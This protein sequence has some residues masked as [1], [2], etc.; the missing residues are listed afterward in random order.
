MSC[1]DQ[2]LHSMSQHLF[3]FLPFFSYFFSYID[4]KINCNFQIYSRCSERR[5]ANTSKKFYMKNISTGSFFHWIIQL[6]PQDLNF[7][8]L[9]RVIEN[10]KQ[11]RWRLMKTARSKI[12]TD[13]VELYNNRISANCRYYTISSKAEHRVFYSLN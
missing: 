6:I 7:S 13:F 10:L 3:V 12:L 9:A 11:V 2:L 1:T 4:I 8:N 5:D